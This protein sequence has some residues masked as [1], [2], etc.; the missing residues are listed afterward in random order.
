MIGSLEVVWSGFWALNVMTRGF[1]HGAHGRGLTVSVVLSHGFLG[2][3][4]LF[5]RI[6][7]QSIGD[8]PFPVLASPPFLDAGPDALAGS[9]S[10]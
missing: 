9:C 8:P 5:N 4:C 2:G 6:W 1:A 10:R 7:G 3:W